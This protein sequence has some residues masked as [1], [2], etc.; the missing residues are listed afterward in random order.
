LAA[1]VTPKNAFY[2]IV[3]PRTIGRKIDPGKIGGR[4]RTECHVNGPTTNTARRHN[5]HRQALPQHEDFS[6]YSTLLNVLPVFA[7]V[8]LGWTVRKLG[9]LGAA[10]TAELNRFVVYLALPALFFD[11]I[12]HARLEALWQP[13]FIVAFGLSCV[14]LFVVT[15]AVSLFGSRPLADAAIDALNASYPNAGFMGFPLALAI[16]GRASLPL[17]LIA[18]IIS[19]SVLFAM[20]IVLI[21]VGGQSDR[22]AGRMLLRVLT[23]LLRNPLVIAPALAAVIP[24]MGW[25]LAGPAESAL[26]LLG[27]AASPCALIAL[28]LFLA[29][30]R[31]AVRPI[32]RLVFFVSTAKLVLQPAVAAGLA[33]ALRLP[34]SIAGPAVLLAALPTGT[35]PFMLAELYGREAD[36]TSRAILVTTLLSLLTI[37][38]YLHFLGA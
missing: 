4:H 35:G 32:G 17:T 13:G 31:R 38:F 2:A 18:A 8:L 29:N 34:A 21:E 19:V 15:L 37:A 9:I 7:L 16:F 25:T 1:G 24:A 6:L 10:A 30:P 5:R 14:L 20:A 36:V 11:V 12:G 23:T 27:G 33:Y 26:K 28:G 3:P 22:H